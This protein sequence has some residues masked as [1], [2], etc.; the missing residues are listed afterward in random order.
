MGELFLSEQDIQRTEST[1]ALRGSDICE[2]I[3]PK[4]SGQ[5]F[6]YGVLDAGPLNRAKPPPANDF[7]TTVSLL[8]GLKQEQV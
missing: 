4:M 7:D 1:V 3:F 5:P 8:E 6:D 2:D